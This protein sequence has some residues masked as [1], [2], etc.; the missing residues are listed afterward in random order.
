MLTNK[1]VIKEITPIYEKQVF[2]LYELLTKE[3]IRCRVTVDSPEGKS[4]FRFKEND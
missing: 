3:P 1:Q 2:G 4:L